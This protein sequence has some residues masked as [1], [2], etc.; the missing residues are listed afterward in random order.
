MTKELNSP[1][2]ARRMLAGLAWIGIDLRPVF[3]RA[4]NAVLLPVRHGLA[5]EVTAWQEELS[6]KVCALQAQ[7]QSALTADLARIEAALERTNR[8]LN[9]RVAEIA[10]HLE[11]ERRERR[12]RVETLESLITGTPGVRLP[13]PRIN[14]T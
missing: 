1:T 14:D 2:I 9:A 4:R 7:I 11:A 10:A 8:E 6:E 12:L 13:E 3:R 5:A